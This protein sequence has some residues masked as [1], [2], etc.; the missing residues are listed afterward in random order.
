MNAHPV[1]LGDQRNT[2]CGKVEL[3]RVLKKELVGHLRSRRRMRHAQSASTAR[4][5]RGRIIHGLSIR[6]RPA[7]ME[8]P[9]IPG[10]W[11]GDLITGSQNRHMATLLERQSRFTM[12]VKVPGKDTASVVTALSTQIRQ[13]PAA[14]RRSLTWVEEWNRPSTNE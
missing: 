3:G 10:H 9:A 5:P 1:G 13:L 6:D 8:G 4:Q 12:L 14:L 7:D 11:E 2:I